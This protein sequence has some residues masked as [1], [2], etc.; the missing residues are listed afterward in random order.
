[1]DEINKRYCDGDGYRADAIK[2]LQAKHK[3]VTV[4][5]IG[6]GVD[7]SKYF[8]HAVKINDVADLGRASFGAII[9]AL[10]K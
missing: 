8:V 1:V 10:K 9:R 3:C 2:A 6:I 4:I 5:G 7:L